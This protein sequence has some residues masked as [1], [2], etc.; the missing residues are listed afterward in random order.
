VVAAGTVAAGSGAG[1]AGVE[2]LSGQIEDSLD[3]PIEALSVECAGDC[4]DVEVTARGGQAPYTFLWEDGTTTATRKVCPEASTTLTAT[5]TDTGEGSEEFG[6]VA[7]SVTVS[8]TVEVVG[9]D[10]PGQP[11]KMQAP[12][13]SFD[14]IEKWRWGTGDVMVTPLVGNLT[15]D[16]GDGFVDLLDTPDVVVSDMSTGFVAVLDGATG[17]EHYRVTMVYAESTPALGDVDG[18]GRMDL[19]L[20]HY[21]GSVGLHYGD[22]GTEIWRTA[23]DTIAYQQGTTLALADLDHDG[24]PEIIAR[25][26]VL[27]HEGNLL[28][29]APVDDVGMY[30]SPVAVD[31]DDDGFLEVVW[32]GLALRHDGTSYY[33][34]TEV[35]AFDP[36]T[37]STLPGQYPAVADLDLDGTP[38]I[39]VATNSTVYVLDNHGNRLHARPHTRTF[40][41]PFPPAIHDVD[42]DGKPEILVSDGENFM[43]LEADLSVDWSMPVVDSSG[44]AAGTA[45]DFLGDGTAEAMYGDESMSWGFDG[46]DGHVVFS[47]ARTSGTII[48]YPTVADVDND[49]SAD[50]LITSSPSWAS[51]PQPPSLIVIGDRDGRWIPAR[52]ILNQDAYHVTNI[53]ENGHVPQHELPHWKLNNSFRAQAQVNESGVV[54]LPEPE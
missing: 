9:C 4:V 1:E 38:E 32:G 37:G 52:R 13:G 18:D 7:Q 34:N 25:A 45:F 20:L 16:N 44:I 10:E 42:G 43:A 47:Q 26:D 31:L 12:Q 27:D 2:T 21:D 53:E 8:L 40:F 22:D 41:L 17:A 30:V 29:S 28:W 19:V 49:G 3:A 11:C 35:L 39:V 54:C 15:D 14:P 6:R 24:A 48:E 51:A 36:T 50:I 46:A 23:P 33:R 5:I